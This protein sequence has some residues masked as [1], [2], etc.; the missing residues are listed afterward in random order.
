V[1][2]FAV[3]CITCWLPDVF[4]LGLLPPATI[5]FAEQET[6]SDT[7]TGVAAT[8]DGPLEWDKPRFTERAEERARMV[9]EQI[10]ARGVD[11]AAVLDAMRRVP[12][13]RFV[14]AQ[15]ERSAYADQPLPI[16]HGQT[17]SQPY[18]VALMTELLEVDPGEAILEIGT[19]SGYQAAVLTEL[20]P[21][22]YTIEI[23]EALG[24]QAAERLAAL[25][26]A[27]VG[28]RIADGYYG[29]EEQAPFDGIIVTCAAG[30]IPPPLLAQLAPGGRMV[31]PVGPVYDVQYLVLV[32][33]DENGTLRSESLLPV[34]FVPMTGRALEES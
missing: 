28:A 2:L 9:V 7:L 15:Y 34:R 13:H 29:W 19:G 25:G 21:Y 17:I 18:I 3:V 5:A 31:I 24:E 20:T 32:A 33:K 12:R 30:H 14:P 16:D 27:T 22:V 6:G 26:Y 8:P 1:I 4:R 11:D 23:I 10:I